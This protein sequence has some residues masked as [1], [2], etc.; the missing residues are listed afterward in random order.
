MALL[1]AGG[2]VLA[3]ET[4]GTTF[5]A[6]EWSWI[7]GRRS[8]GA[9]TFLEP[10][11]QHLSLVP[12][13]IYKLLFATV[14]L[15]HYG[16]YRAVLIA[17]DLACAALVFAYV[18]RRLGGFLALLAA[19][20][21]LLFGPGWQ[22]ILWPFQIGW[23]IAIGA[24]VSALLM[25]DRRERRGDIAAAILLMV[26]LASSSVGLAIAVGVAIDVLQRRRR[27]DWWIFL[28][29]LAVYVLW[30][31]A[32]QHTGFHRHALVLLPRFVFDAAAGV[33]SS[34]TGLAGIDVTH[35]TGASCHGG[36]RC[37]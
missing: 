6:D 25:L 27:G 21:I 23:L 8:G 4:R 16:P 26:S 5:W 9:G 18:R 19:A 17:C 33:M 2:V 24:G 1:V 20:L 32:Y 36:R 12:V 11:N 31:L 28:A 37:W 15:R 13:A 3:Y 22:D 10:H 7:L 35:D 30:W 34:L 14:G 29:P